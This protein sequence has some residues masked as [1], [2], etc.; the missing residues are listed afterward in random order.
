MAG[1]FAASGA[2]LLLI[3]A[4]TSKGQTLTI[5]DNIMTTMVVNATTTVST[6]CFE[7][8]AG[9]QS[10]NVT[11]G[12][13]TN[14]TLI[15]VACQNCLEK[16]NS[17]IEARNKL[18]SDAQLANPAYTPQIA[19]D[20][21]VTEMLTGSFS[22]TTSATALAPCT[23]LCSDIVLFNTAQ[24]LQLSTSQDCQEENNITTDISQAVKGQISAYLKN[25]QDIIGQLESAFTSNQEKLETDLATTMSQSIVNNF[26]QD[27]NQHLTAMQFINISGNSIVA[28]N[29]SQSFTGDMVGKLQVTNTVADNL[30]QSA[31]FSIAQSLINKNSTIGDLTQDFLQVI[32]TISDLLEQ[33]TS[34]IILILAAIITAFVLVVGTLFLFSRSFQDWSKSALGQVKD[35][36]VAKQTAK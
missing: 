25:Q 24:S 18:E 29:I 17:I 28:T 15:P 34:Q 4:L 2:A 21:L 33:L 5:T 9:S 19:N 16:I 35:K 7:S 20:N 12:N 30:R 36:Y 32:Q 13:N 27:L 3:D 22:P 1:A 6:N 14:N 11:T 10:L 31:Q 8:L 23:A 26:I